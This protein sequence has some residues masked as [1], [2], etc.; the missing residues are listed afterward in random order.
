MSILSK[1][2][3]IDDL[4]KQTKILTYERDFLQKRLDKIRQT[5][6]QLVHLL[7]T[8]TVQEHLMAQGSDATILPTNTRHSYPPS[9][10]KEKLNMPQGPHPW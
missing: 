4:L 9:A 8:F 2:Q 5:K 1:D 7:E 3:Q 10:Y 6:D